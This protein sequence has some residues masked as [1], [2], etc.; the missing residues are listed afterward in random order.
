MNDARAVATAIVIG[1]K[2]GRGKIGRPE[3]STQTL[4]EANGEKA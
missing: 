4:A 2:Q 3:V 1:K